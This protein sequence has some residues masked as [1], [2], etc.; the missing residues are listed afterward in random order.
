[1]SADTYQV[2][3]IIAFSLAAVFFILAVILFIKFNIPGLINDLSG[4]TAI[5]QIQEIRRQNIMDNIRKKTS[6]VY[7]TSNTP[8]VEAGV[9]DIRK[10]VSIKKGG[11]TTAVI[12]KEQTKTDISYQNQESTEL[13]NHD[14]GTEILISNK[15]GEPLSYNVATEVL[16][17]NINGGTEVLAWNVNG[18]TEV[19]AQ[20]DAKEERRMYG[21]TEEL[22]DY[23]EEQIE[24]VKF[25]IVRSIIIVHSDVK[26]L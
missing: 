11:N 16:A 23:Y 13:L 7:Q 12:G 24:P 5:K 15:N 19:L 8:S 17:Q 2:I 26:A 3:S 4:R 10:N 21:V 18:G 22:T 9:S 20:N 14:S 25:N 6:D 1:M